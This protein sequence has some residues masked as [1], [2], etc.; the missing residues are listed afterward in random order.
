MYSTTQPAAA[1]ITGEDKL[2]SRTAQRRVL[3]ELVAH[4]SNSTTN[5]NNLDNN[6]VTSQPA[7]AAR[8]S[9]ARGSRV[10]NQRSGTIGAP[11]RGPLGTTRPG[12]ALPSCS[13]SSCTLHCCSSALVTPDWPPRVDSTLRSPM[14]L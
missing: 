10:L 5:Y 4:T 12:A 7:P 9:N 13:S 14:V 2:G 6:D 8:I 3:A 1:V 11:S